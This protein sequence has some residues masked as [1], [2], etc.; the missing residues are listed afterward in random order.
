LQGKGSKIEN[1][2]AA[3]RIRAVGRRIAMALIPGSGVGGVA[4]EAV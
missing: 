4:Y 3:A 1:E 2:A